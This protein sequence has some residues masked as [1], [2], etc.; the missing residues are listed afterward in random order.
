M[1]IARCPA[2]TPQAVCCCQMPRRG[3]D[4][5]ASAPSRRRAICTL[6]LC[7]RCCWCCGHRCHSADG[8]RHCADPSYGCLLSWR[9]LVPELPNAVQWL[10]WHQGL[11]GTVKPAAARPAAAGD[12][13]RPAGTGWRPAPPPPPAGRPLE[14]QRRRSDEPPPG[15]APPPRG[16]C[17]PVHGIVH[18]AL[19]QLHLHADDKRM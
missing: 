4:P 6:P 7:S 19:N 14:V 12:S 15:A 16:A 1:W 2:T 8:C 13:G 9:R 5:A 10:A 17:L 18:T 11:G 3:T